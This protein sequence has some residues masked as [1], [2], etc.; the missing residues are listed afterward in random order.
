MPANTQIVPNILLNEFIWRQT[1]NNYASLCQVESQDK[2][3]IE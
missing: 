2:F 3:P 1:L